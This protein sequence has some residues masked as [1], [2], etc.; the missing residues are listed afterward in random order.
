MKSGY[1]QF[2]KNARK[3]A[4]QGRALPRRQI[5]KPEGATEE[6]MKKKIGM[7]QAKPPVQFPWKLA[8][9]SLVGF[10]LAFWG[11]NNYEKVESFIQSVEVN[12]MGSAL[13]EEKPTEAAAKTTAKADEKAPAEEVITETHLLKLNDRKKELDL[14]EEELNRMEAEITEQK[15]DLEKRLKELDDMRRN[16]SSVLEEKVKGDEQKLDTLVQMY[17]NM[18][19]QQAAKI[20][21]SMDEGLAVDILSR[22]KKKNAAEIMNLLKPEKAQTFSEKYAGYKTK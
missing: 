11:L 15:L 19:A 1:D 10:A 21:E 2:F 17:T 14:R 6:Q 8:G 18:K 13:A 9:F 12:I 5:A 4:D 3:S 16:I 7:K 22:M 20:F